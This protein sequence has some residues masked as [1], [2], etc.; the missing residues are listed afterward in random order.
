MTTNKR[1]NLVIALSIVAFIIRGRGVGISSARQVKAPWADDPTLHRPVPRA[2][3]TWPRE[4]SA[5]QVRQQQLIGDCRDLLFRKDPICR[6]EDDPFLNP[7]KKPTTHGAA[8][9]CCAS[10]ILLRIARVFAAA[11]WKPSSGSLIPSPSIRSLPTPLIMS[12]PPNQFTMI[13]FAGSCYQGWEEGY[14]I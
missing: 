13:R 10:L 4:Q 1:S 11:A 5:S 8:K 9:T 12:I 2:E 14:Y 3:P 7:L 6:R